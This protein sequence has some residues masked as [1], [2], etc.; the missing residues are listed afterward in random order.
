MV[1][2][3]LVHERFYDRFCISLKNDY[4]KFICNQISLAV[5]LEATHKPFKPL[6]NLT[7]HPQ[8][9]QK[10][11][12]RLSCKKTVCSCSNDITTPITP[13][14]LQLSPI[15]LLMFLYI[16]LKAEKVLVRENQMNSFLWSLHFISNCK[17]RKI[18]NSCSSSFTR[19]ICIETSFGRPSEWPKPL[20]FW[21]RAAVFEKWWYTLNDLKHPDIKIK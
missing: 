4:W 20:V 21:T 14:F 16:L 15:I 2:R 12:K 9:N 18:L 13:F 1:L 3:L 11:A 5:N 6:T 17:Q 8:T 10:T 19:L 7:N